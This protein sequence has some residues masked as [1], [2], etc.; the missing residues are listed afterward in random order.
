MEKT[1]SNNSIGLGYFSLA[2]G[3]GMVLILLGHSMTPF[4]AVE[5]MGD[6]LW[7]NAGSVLG[8]GIM[9]MFFLI[10][11]FGFYSR[12]L[13]KCWNT[14]W[15][16]L[17]KPY[18]I[19]A[20][21]IIATKVL[22]AVVK[23]RPFADHGGDLVLTYLLGMNAEGGGTFLGIG[24]DSVS[25]MWFVL[26]LFG[27]WLIYN[28]ICRLNSVRLQYAL[29]SGAVV[30][31]WLLTLVSDVWPWCLPMALLAVGYLAAGDLIRRKN[32][33]TAKLPAWSWVLLT[34]V[35][36][37]CF[38]FGQVNMVACRWKL[39]ILDVAGSFC[40][41]FLLLRGYCWLMDKIRM[42]GPVRI[43]ESV[44]FHSL[45]VVFL[46]GYEKVIFPWYR[47]GNLLPESPV[48]CVLLCLALR[49]VVIFVLMRLVLWGRRNLRKK[50][51]KTGIV[52]Q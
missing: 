42:V 34:A 33:L 6:M 28:G 7:S 48:L 18:C 52:L 35:S 4:F 31:G 12:S 41:G 17:L 49:S 15:K 9:A 44:G 26:A 30:V 10:S 8:G 27:G 5:N 51:V 45:W 25:I 13:R 14:Q 40:V 19:T 22:L 50:R 38:A 1:R 21:A 46:H 37:C 3:I 47:L 43:L 29:V 16:L 24:V 36:V 23:Q 2:R 32:W 11:G 20:A 39:G